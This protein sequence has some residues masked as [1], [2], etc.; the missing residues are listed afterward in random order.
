MVPEG[1][2]QKEL[3]SLLPGAAISL[4]ESLL[5]RAKINQLLILSRSLE[6]G[7]VSWPNSQRQDYRK[8]AR[9]AGTS[10]S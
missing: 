6:R 7:G 1:C 10:S 4:S 9:K 5:Y 3:S 2:N 8:K